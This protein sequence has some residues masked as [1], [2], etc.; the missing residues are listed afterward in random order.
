MVWTLLLPYLLIELL[1]SQDAIRCPKCSSYR[2]FLWSLFVF[3]TRIV[4]SYLLHYGYE[5]TLNSLCMAT[6]SNVTP[7]SMDQGNGFD[8]QDILY[9]LSQRKTLRQV[10]HLK[11]AILMYAAATLTIH[12]YPP[13]DR[14][15]FFFLPLKYSGLQSYPT[16]WLQHCGWIWFWLSYTTMQMLK[17]VHGITSV[18]SQFDRK[19]RPSIR[20]GLFLGFSF[21]V[22]RVYV[23]ISPEMSIFYW[24]VEV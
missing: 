6:K 10:Q 19:L 17:V 1:I 7:V 2:C 4:R 15:F 24:Y 9:A 18:P 5:N 11:V 23:E 21:W 14:S 3:N 20:T 16:I 22:V 12:P 13:L 8:E